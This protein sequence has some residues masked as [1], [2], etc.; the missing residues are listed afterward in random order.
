MAKQYILDEPLRQEI[1]RV[2]AI[3][4][5]FDRY[6]AAAYR[7]LI[8]DLQYHRHISPKMQEH[9]AQYERQGKIITD[10]DDDMVAY[11]R[12]T[13][14]LG[15]GPKTALEWVNMGIL[16]LADV[17]KALSDGKL[18]LTTMQKYGLLYYDQLCRPIPRAEVK[19]IGSWIIDQI[20]GQRAEI[21]GSYRRQ[22]EYS[23][24][25]DIVC[26]SPALDSLR[27]N[28]NVVIL[29]DGPSKTML[30]VIV[31]HGSSQKVYQV[32]IQHAMASNYA[33]MLLYFTGSKDHNI[34]MRKQAIRLGY[35]LSEWGLYK[36]NKKI[37]CRTERDVFDRLKM[38]YV[39]P[40]DRL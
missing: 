2:I 5:I 23:N 26:C 8:V 20:K 34:A 32:D 36:D 21:V 37:V 27:D 22:L 12:L 31:C 7:K 17:R 9:L 4:D 25:I 1:E 38:R 24:D 11:G 16:T 30:L 19:K 39:E 6:R 10:Y 35:T 15:V 40:W 13:K 3:Y 18:E 29:K 14:M 33:T 28:P